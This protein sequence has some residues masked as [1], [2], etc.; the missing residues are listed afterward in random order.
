[1]RQS[2]AQQTVLVTGGAVRIGREICLSFARR[3]A[4]VVV[5]CNRSLA[6]AK[7]LLSELPDR[8]PA[9]EIVVGDLRDGPFRRGLLPSLGKRGISLTCLVNNASTYRRMPL[10]NATEDRLR[11]DFEINFFVPF[12]LMRD[13][14]EHCGRGCIVNLLDQRVAVVDS[15]AGGYGLAKKALRDATEAAALEWAPDIRV[16]AVAPGYC[17]PPPGVD[18]AKMIPLLQN[19]PMRRASAPEEI[20]AAC[21]FLVGSPTLAGQTVFVDG[22]MHLRGPAPEGR[23]LATARREK[24]S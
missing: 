7:A 15:G 14:A 21:V 4:R 12:L 11:E 16:N 17:L 20:A 1:M 24:T 10:K 9:H 23:P 5:H 3:G 6:A 18:E 2:L 22:G 8:Q 19:I 13:F